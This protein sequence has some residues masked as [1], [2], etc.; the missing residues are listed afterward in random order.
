MTVEPPMAIQKIL[1]KVQGVT[2]MHTA[3][4]VFNHQN[5]QKTN[6]MLLIEVVS[7]TDID[8]KTNEKYYFLIS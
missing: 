3:M 7:R 5:K 2:R 4:D 6:N 8:R 1:D